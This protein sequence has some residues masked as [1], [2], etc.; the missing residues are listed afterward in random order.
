MKPTAKPNEAGKRYLKS[1]Q[2]ENEETKQPPI[3]MEP[4]MSIN[5]LGCMILF[6]KRF[7]PMKFPNILKNILIENNASTSAS[8]LSG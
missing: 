2:L 1:A 7:A 5:H 8:V 4:P 6:L 3:P